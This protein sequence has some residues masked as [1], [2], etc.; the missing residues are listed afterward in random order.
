MITI[1][2]SKQAQQELHEIHEYIAIE[3]D[4]QTAAYD[5]LQK[6]IEALDTLIEFPDI[7]SPMR[8]ILPLERNYRFLVVGEYLIVYR[9]EVESETVYV[10]RIL[11]GRSDY[12]KTLFREPPLS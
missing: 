10:L 9:H 5:I 12:M 11:Y 3:L 8:S 1:R 4:N 6:M 2:L 7:G